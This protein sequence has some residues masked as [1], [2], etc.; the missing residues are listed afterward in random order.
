M[1][2]PQIVWDS[3]IRHSDGSFVL[4]PVSCSKDELLRMKWDQKTHGIARI[5]FEVPEN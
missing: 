2:Q 1:N 5:D 4:Q 3:E